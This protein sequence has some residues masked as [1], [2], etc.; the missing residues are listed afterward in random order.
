MTNI[1][2]DD[3]DN[4]NEHT[5]VEHG[6]FY[7]CSDCGKTATEGSKLKITVCNGGSD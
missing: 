6:D 3:S 7:K 4:G 2:E 1:F 5:V